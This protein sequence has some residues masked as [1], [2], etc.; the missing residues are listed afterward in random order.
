MKRRVETTIVFDFTYGG[1]AYGAT[2]TNLPL[3]PN[4][5][6][7][8]P[9]EVASVIAVSKIDGEGEIQI[10]FNRAPA[11]LNSLIIIGNIARY[12][13][14][15]FWCQARFQIDALTISS[16][17]KIYFQDFRGS[18][19]ESAIECI[20]VVLEGLGITKGMYNVPPKVTQRTL[21]WVPPAK[22]FY[23]PPHFN[24]LNMGW[25]DYGVFLEHQF[26][27]GRSPLTK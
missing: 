16:V 27:L 24:E 1:K 7:R 22:G 12:V 23:S 9:I 20:V 21:T 13:P 5:P 17:T 15:D 8:G 6:N 19:C 10:T 14:R 26:K 2:P 18:F 4:D 3:C 25:V 11:Y